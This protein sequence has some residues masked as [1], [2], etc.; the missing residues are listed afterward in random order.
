MRR[1][2]LLAVFLVSVGFVGLSAQGYSRTWRMDKWKSADSYGNEIPTG[3]RVASVNDHCYYKSEDGRGDSGYAIKI[4]NKASS[5]SNRL[6]SPALDFF[7]SGAGTYVVTFYTKG[8]GKLVWINLANNP[9][10]LK[11][12]VL[13]NNSKKDLQSSDWKRHDFEFKVSDPSEKYHLFFLINKTDPSDP[14]LFDD[15][16]VRKKEK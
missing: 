11:D 6:V 7:N 14:V 15:L 1:K 4:E 5:H 2:I 8:T 3:F 13:L 12:A 10:S 9:S 16:S